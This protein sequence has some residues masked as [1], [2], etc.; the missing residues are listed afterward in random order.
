MVKSESF[1]KTTLH[2]I[3]VASVYLFMYLPLIILIMNSFNGSELASKWSGI[4]L[5]WYQELFNSP[6]IASATWNSLVV[7][8]TSTTLCIILG[9]SFV[10]G[11]LRNKITFSDALFYPNIFTPDIVLALTVLS[12][13]KFLGLA[14]GF[15][16]LIIGHTAIGLV[17]VIP[18]IRTRINELDKNLIEASLD[19]GANYL[20]TTQKIILPLLMP[21]IVTAAFMAF[22]ISLDDFFISF[23]CSGNEIETLSLYIFSHQRTQ[24]SPVL[25]ALSTCMIIGSILLLASLF[26]LQKHIE[27]RAENAKKL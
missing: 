4:T 1:I 15:T 2:T 7:A 21:A 27:R 3:F 9:T 13:F 12:L 26:G 23:F 18:I 6:E 11:T 20:Y 25:S 17:F 19:L 5:S 14:C 16:S 22:T 24:S 8:I 10:I